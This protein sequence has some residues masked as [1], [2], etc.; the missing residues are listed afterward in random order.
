MNIEQWL[1]DT[2][3][4][5]INELDSNGA[6]EGNRWFIIRCGSREHCEGYA[7]NFT[8]QGHKFAIFLPSTTFDHMRA[9]VKV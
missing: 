4:N 7:M 8:Y 1:T 5:L 6:V 9:L 3:K 2:T